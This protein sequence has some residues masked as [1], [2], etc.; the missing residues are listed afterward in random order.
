MGVKEERFWMVAYLM[1]VLLLCWAIYALLNDEPKD[2]FFGDGGIPL[3]DSAAE[4]VQ[5]LIPQ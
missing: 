4:A 2:V 3:H 5:P 1:V